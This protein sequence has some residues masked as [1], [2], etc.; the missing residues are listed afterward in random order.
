MYS[1]ALAK[2]TDD[3]DELTAL[4]ELPAGDSLR[5]PTTNPIDSTRRRGL[6]VPPGAR[7]ERGPMVVP[8]PEAAA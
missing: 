5:P 1:K 6:L 4:H 3:E 8:V 7:R 2:T